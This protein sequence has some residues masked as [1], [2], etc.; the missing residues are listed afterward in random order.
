MLNSGPLAPLCESMTSSTKPEVH[1][2]LHYRQR[3]TET[4]PRVKSRANLEKLG[5]LAFEICEQTDRQTNR[6][7]DCNISPPS[8]GQVIIE[9]V[10]LRLLG[11]MRNIKKVSAL[12]EVKSEV[13]TTENG[14][15]RISLFMVVYITTCIRFDF[16]EANDFNIYYY[17]YY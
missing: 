9:L 13:F 2:I 5:H 15:V 16:S 10:L 11:S 8:R 1:K 7:A 12:M 6:H 14:H 3:R 4:R 17:Y